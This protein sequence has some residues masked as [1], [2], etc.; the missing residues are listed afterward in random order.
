MSISEGFEDGS[1]L[2][3]VG[4]VNSEWNWSSLSRRAFSRNL[5]NH[6][7]LLSYTTLVVVRFLRH[8][9]TLPKWMIKVL[10]VLFFPSAMYV[11]AC[12]HRDFCVHLYMFV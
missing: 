12:A 10:G 3:L 6:I 8:Q 9:A 4:S 11:G 7:Q 2:F 1:E 5:D